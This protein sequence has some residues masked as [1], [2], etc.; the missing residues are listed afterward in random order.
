MARPHE[1]GQALACP[2][3]EPACS[4]A[5]QRGPCLLESSSASQSQACHTRN[6][7]LSHLCGAE[8]LGYTVGGSSMALGEQGYVLGQEG[9]LCTRWVMG[10]KH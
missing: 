10:A 6:P 9:W 4:L 2:L 7:S 5:P 1:P 8:V 3:A